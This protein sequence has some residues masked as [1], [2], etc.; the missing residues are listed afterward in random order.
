MAHY[1]CSRLGSDKFKQLQVMKFSWPSKIVDYVSINSASVNKEVD[2]AEF[3]ELF[4]HD[5]V[6]AKLDSSWINKK[7]PFAL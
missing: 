3:E 6:K 1:Q 2:L 5:C 4:G 7:G